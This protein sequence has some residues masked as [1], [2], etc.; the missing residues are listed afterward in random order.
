MKIVQ[1]IPG[2]G[3][4]FYCENCLRDSNLSKAL[5]KQGHDVLRLPLYLPIISE[6]PIRVPP[7][8]RPENCQSGFLAP[9]LSGT[10]FFGGINVYLQQKSVLFRKT[11]RWIDRIFDSPRL[12]KWAASKGGMTKAEELGEMTLSMLRGQEG[13]QVKELNRLITW[14]ASRELPD[15]IHLSNA[16]LL[17]VVRRI[18]RELRIPVVCSLQD[19]D[20]WVDALPEAQRQ[21]V[22][23]TLAQR[24]VDVDAFISVSEYY[25]DFICD[26]L[27]IPADRVHVVYSGIELESYQQSDLPVDPPVIGYLERQCREKGLGILIEAFVILKRRGRLRDSPGRAKLLLNHLKL[28]IAGGKLVDDDPFIEQM[29]Q[30]LADEGLSEDVAFLPN[31]NFEDRLAFLRSL[32]MLSVPAEHK[33][34]F[35][36]YVIEALASGVP[37]VQPRHGAFPELLAAT[38]GGILCEPGNPHALADAIETLL[39]DHEQARELGIQGRRAVFESF[40]MENMARNVVKLL[41]LVTDLGSPSTREAEQDCL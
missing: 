8:R 1:L 12:L 23:E 15:V 35:G 40:G 37:V 7:T 5:Y 27:K 4:A 29:H 39:L 26:R 30:R 25:K 22:W 6:E 13:R 16:L 17:G 24:A 11:P 14:L 2:S 41:G 3:G 36:I 10:L 38:K 19:E 34:A 18:K 33:E 21:T 9:R 28:R 20:I 32:S 31:L